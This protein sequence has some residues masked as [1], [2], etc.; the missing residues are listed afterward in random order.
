M[1]QNNE[2]EMK[3]FLCVRKSTRKINKINP[4]IGQVV[5][6]FLYHWLQCDSTLDFGFLHNHLTVSSSHCHGG[7][8]S[9]HFQS[10]RY[11]STSAWVHLWLVNLEL[12]LAQQNYCFWYTTIVSFILLLNY[13]INKCQHES[14]PTSFSSLLKNG[15]F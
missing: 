15:I 6:F 4:F 8:L 13:L 9:G 7:L 14:E 5:W 12:C 11:Y 2:Q 3:A 1:L 10:L